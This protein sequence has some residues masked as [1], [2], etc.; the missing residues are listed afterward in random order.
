MI[1]RFL[2]SGLPAFAMTMAPVLAGATD[3]NFN[4]QTLTVP[5]G[6]IVERVAS[7]PLTKRPISADYDNEG[8]LYV[9]ESSGSNASVEEQLANKPHRIVRLTDTDGDGQYDQRR[10]FAD[11]FPF[12]EG[13]LWHKGSL[14]VA[15]P[16][17]IWKLT[18]TNDDG[19]AD[20]RE[21]WF[22]GKTLTHCANDL[23][24]PELGP[25]GRIYWCKGAFAKQHYKLPDG[26]KLTT[27]AAHIFRA[28]QDAS[29]IEPVLTGGMDNPV[30]VAFTPGGERI[31]AGTFFQHPGGGNRDGLIHAV[32]GGVYGK[33][34]DVIEDHRRTGELMPIM[35]HLGPAAPCSIIRY[36]SKIFGNDYHNAFFSA[37]FNLNKVM[38]HRLTPQGAT[39]Q[40]KDKDFLVSDSNDFHPTCV[41]EAPDGSLIIVDTGGWYKIC[42]PTSQLHKPDV[43]G[44]IYRV[45]RKSAPKIAH[46]L[47]N[48]MAWHDVTP[49]ELTDRLKSPRPFVRDR[50]VTALR[51]RGK[52]AIPALKTV[53]QESNTPSARLNAVWTLA[54]LAD[55][56]ARNAVRDALNDENRT[57][58]HAAANV[59]GLWRDDQ[60]VDP[61]VALLRK[62][63]P[64]LQRIAAEALGRIGD[65]NAVSPLLTATAES[66]KRILEHSIIY[67]LIEIGDTEALR[68]GLRARN[69]HAQR[70]SLIALDQLQGSRLSFRQVEPFLTATNPTLRKTAFWVIEH[71]TEWG[72]ELADYFKNR[73]FRAS[74]GSEAWQRFTAQLADF[75]HNPKVQTLVATAVV[76]ASLPLERRRSLLGS[77][78]RAQPDK[79]PREWAESIKQL[80]THGPNSLL[81]TATKTLEAITHPEA[82]LPEAMAAILTR[83][84]G[85]DSLAADTRLDAVAVKTR[86]SKRISPDNFELVLANLQKEKPIKRRKA[87][88]RILKQVDL[89]ESHLVRLAGRLPQLSALDLRDILALFEQSQ[90]RDV[91]ERLVASL[92]ELDAAA[93][94]QPKPLESLLKK[95]PKPIQ[96]SAASFI[97]SLREQSTEKREHLETLLSSLGK[98]NPRRGEKIFNSP[99][100]ACASCHAIGY[101]G[102]KLGPDL[103]N[104]GQTRT[105]RDLLESIIYPGASFV[106]SYESVRVKT[107]AGR[108]YNGILRRDSPEAVTL[109]TGPG[110]E[111]TIKREEIATM[112]PSDISLMP[113]GLGEVLTKQELADLLAFLK[114]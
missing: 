64:P 88:I 23:H 100:A 3:F 102:G 22:N 107:T 56:Q 80:L 67:A 82:D 35:A 93:G 36:R 85:N 55:S 17:A 77:M 20:R 76:D 43:L 30:S 4:N 37:L 74:G 104:I 62:G 65:S 40:S 70:A 84:A 61:L 57:I 1:A 33:K 5:D 6:F 92:S 32:Y 28:R 113:Q 97:S 24:G 81:P 90:S 79:L 103:T 12:P 41:L 18:D 73:L 91:G 27:K 45:R 68:R 25:D 10:V 34:H 26:R 58:R 47:G 15:A 109:A 46:P 66:P 53:L 75:A 89:T 49:K 96:E 60:A 9:T 2:L 39:F 54:G 21:K 50:T 111:Q 8:N 69:A 83:I 94:L 31:L 86:T 87:A 42:C 114:K 38:H 52:E 101:L 14:Y 16:P 11:D 108:V 29:A 110:V 71:H 48:E 105:R 106:R 7:P 112:R 98:G 19:V 13:A 63:S 44:G 95:Y 59:A 51:K 99:R 72:E 78:R